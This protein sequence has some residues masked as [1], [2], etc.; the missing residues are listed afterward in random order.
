MPRKSRRGWRFPKKEMREKEREED[1]GLFRERKR[2]G[3]K[4]RR[5]SFVARADVCLR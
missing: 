4:E 1:D 2:R 3:G 5:P